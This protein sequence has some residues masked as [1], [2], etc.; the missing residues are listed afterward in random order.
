MKIHKINE[1]IIKS[2]DPTPGLT[3]GAVEHAEALLAC[4]KG[5]FTDDLMDV[6]PG[7]P[8][9]IPV[10]ILEGVEAGDN[11]VFEPGSITKKEG[12]LELQWQIFSARGHDGAVIVGRID[13]I[14][15][16]E[17]QEQPTDVS[18]T[19]EDIAAGMMEKQEVRKG[20]GRAYGVFDSNGVYGREAERLVRGGFLRGVSADMDMFEAA[21]DVAEED[22]DKDGVIKNER[23]TVRKARLIAV[24]LVTKPAFQ[25]AQIKIEEPED[26]IVF[27]EDSPILDGTYEEIMDDTYAIAASAAPVVPPKTWFR[28]PQL[29]KKTPITVTDDGQVF[30]HIAA[31]D[32]SHIGLPRSTRPPRSASKYAYFTTGVL[33][34]DDGSDVPVGQLTLAGGHAALHASAQEAIKHYDDTASAVADVT[35]GEDQHGIW[36]AGA[37]RPS[38]SPEQVRVLRA[39]APSGDWRPINGRLELV[40]ICQVN[41]PGFPIAR[42]LVAS[43]KV[44][45]LVAAGARP[46]AE[47]RAHSL[48]ERISALEER[49]F[50][51]ELSAIAPAFERLKELERAS[52]VAS[53]FKSR[54]I[55][56][57]LKTAALT[58]ERKKAEQRISD[59]LGIH[60]Q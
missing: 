17:E 56:E 57:S 42:S 19:T 10:V 46:M 15:R 45:S 8:F 53:A 4:G 51:T 22:E 13:H 55:L 5:S 25:E 9:S 35:I 60:T 6:R 47:I 34:V 44:L 59:I 26:N 31:W 54:E 29:S 58:A 18:A 2:I 39:S 41:V 40:A 33:R 20:W 50:S 30:G 49:H 12:P 24:T 3:A 7:T 14:E 37:L 43:G 21:A 1:D 27:Y 48:E 23:I 52:L 11:R 36:V 16:L 32:V 38:V 28:D